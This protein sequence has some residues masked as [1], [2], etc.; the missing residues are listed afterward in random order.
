[1][2]RT[3]R[4]GWPAPTGRPSPRAGETEVK[5]LCCHAR[6][7]FQPAHGRIAGKY[8]C[9]RSLELIEIWKVAANENNP[10]FDLIGQQRRGRRIGK[11][12]DRHVG[13]D[14]PF[15]IGRK[16]EVDATLVGEVRPRPSHRDRQE[17]RNARG[18][19]RPAAQDI[20]AVRLKSHRSRPDPAAGQLGEPAVHNS[21]C[22]CSTSPTAVARV[23]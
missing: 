2:R 20:V 6:M 3:G 18:K 7:G 15:G 17:G 16:A 5:Q 4:Q 21:C 23:A 14:R 10:S 22:H 1:M 11:Q 19:R 13:E 9:C 12:V 8:P